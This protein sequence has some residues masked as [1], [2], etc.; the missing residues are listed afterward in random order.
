MITRV[1][2]SFFVNWFTQTKGFGKDAATFFKKNSK[3][4]LL[5]DRWCGE[6]SAGC[7]HSVTQQWFVIL[8]VI[9]I[10]LLR[11][12]MC[13]L[14][15]KQFAKLKDEEYSQTQQLS[16]ISLPRQKKLL[17]DCCAGFYLKGNTTMLLPNRSTERW[18]FL[19]LEWERME[20]PSV[21]LGSFLR[22]KLMGNVTIILHQLHCL[23]KLIIQITI[24]HNR[25]RPFG[26]FG[27]Y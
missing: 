4:L 3:A 20:N 17:R 23:R 11:D 21:T 7:S 22:V 14:F 12:T 10:L 18:S 9:W 2:C 26:P 25:R 5:T 16:G 1:S 8:T 13:C 24:S 19:N 27:L 15:W 6:L